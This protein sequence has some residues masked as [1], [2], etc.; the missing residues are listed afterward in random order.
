MKRFLPV[1]LILLT[2]CRQ[3]INSNV[4]TLAVTLPPP[5]ISVVPTDAIEMEPTPTI[6]PATATPVSFPLPDEL[7]AGSISMI[8]MGDSL[9]VGVGDELSGGYVNRLLTKLISIRPDVTVTN[10]AQPD[11]DSGLIITGVD[12]RLGQLQLAVDVV[13]VSQSHDRST[14]ALLWT[15]NYDIWKLYSSSAEVTAEMEQ[16]DVQRFAAN[17]TQ[18]LSVLRGEGAY[19]VVAT[20]DDQ[21]KRP[22]AVSGEAFPDITPD[23]YIKMTAQVQRYNA[24]IAT[25]ADQYGVYTVDFFNT[26]IFSDPVTISSDGL[27]P[28]SAGYE[29]IAEK[30]YEVLA[31]LIT[32]G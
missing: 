17:L 19:V 3:E 10:F 22:A 20:I 27:H 4:N 24:V 9:T 13:K 18:M 15:G 32:P 25:A 29:L 11:W 21:S 8:A 31:P 26:T 2:S 6:A 14:L 23:E 7:P 5:E 30:W 28:N 12:G 1:L 16:Q